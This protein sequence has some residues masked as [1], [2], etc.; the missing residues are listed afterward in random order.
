MNNITKIRC[1]KCGSE[2]YDRYDTENYGNG[3]HFDYCYCEEC[4]AQFDV[5]YVAVE[6]T[7]D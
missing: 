7:L 5:K 1:P 4:D 3:V 6:I 2:N